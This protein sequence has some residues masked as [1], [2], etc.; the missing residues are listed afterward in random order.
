MKQDNFKENLLDKIENLKQKPKYFFVLEQIFFVIIFLFS[1]GFAFYFISFIGFLLSEKDIF[2]APFF[3]LEGIKILFFSL[4]WFLFLIAFI[5]LI[6]SLI[7]FRHFEYAYKK[8]VIISLF[9][10]IFF[11]IIS[12]II[13]VE[14]GIQKF[15]KEESFRRNIPIA[16]KPLKDFRNKL[17][18]KV[19]V[20]KVI[21]TTTDSVLI[22]RKDGR[23]FEI[24]V[25]TNTIGIQKKDLENIKVNQNI[26]VFGDRKVK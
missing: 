2:Y 7:I 25:A 21:G 23:I 24:E 11:L 8:P 14:T 3:G 19:F 15:V 13:F 26:K 17:P 1:L 4:P 18:E 5:F 22:K 20:G 10:I 16:P 6:L 12:H 9:G